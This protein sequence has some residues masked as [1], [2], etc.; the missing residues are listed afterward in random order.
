MQF[1]LT[2]F[3][4][5]LAAVTVVQAI[6]PPITEVLESSVKA[7]TNGIDTL[8]ISTALQA[9]GRPVKAARKFS[10]LDSSLDNLPVRKLDATL[11]NE[12][13]AAV[14]PIEHTSISLIPPGA[15][16]KVPRENNPIDLSVDELPARRL[17]S[18]FAKQSEAADDQVA[19]SLQ[20]PGAPVKA[21]VENILTDSSAK[22]SEKLSDRHFKSL[23]QLKL[24][25]M[26][27]NRLSR[28]SHIIDMKEFFAK[29]D[30]RS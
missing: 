15:S 8:T 7:L 24:D 28:E 14:F 30:Q 10:L 29:L 25:E 18:D 27:S 19:A 9:P 2:N 21:L 17:G 23:I 4:L 5:F 11:E 6:P 12:V 1:I 26:K 3:A 20:L 13:S 22:N 16:V